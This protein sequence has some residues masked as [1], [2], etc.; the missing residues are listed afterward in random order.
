MFRKILDN[1][2]G[3][4]QRRRELA[5]EEYKLE[6]EL[7]SLNESLDNLHKSVD[8]ITKE[9]E[10]TDKLLAE[11]IQKTVYVEA[12]NTMKDLFDDLDDPIQPRGFKFRGLV[13]KGS[14]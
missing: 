6:K 4:K 3:A 11:A 9:C 10:E 2:P 5:V 13:R 12:L 7:K 1:L 8:E 14:L